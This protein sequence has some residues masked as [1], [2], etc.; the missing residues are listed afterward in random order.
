MNAQLETVTTA[1]IHFKKGG[2]FHTRPL[3]TALEPGAKN[4]VWDADTLTLSYVTEDN[5]GAITEHGLVLTQQQIDD[6]AAMVG[7]YNLDAAKAAKRDK[8]AEACE[9]E[10]TADLVS[11]GIPF[12]AHLEAIIDVQMLI[13]S[14]APEEVFQGY[15][16]SDD[17]FR[18]IS[19]EQF[20][21]ALQAGVAR[22]VAAFAKRKTLTETINAATTAAELEAISW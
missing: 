20:Q 6:A 15:K 19:R 5:E 13:E 17:V 3:P 22:K 1:G 4:G 9:A 11:E 7:A 16:C 2:G 8:I 14:L 21:T 10:Y 18:D 12:R